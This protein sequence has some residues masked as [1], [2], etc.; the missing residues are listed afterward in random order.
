MIRV[1]LTLKLV[2]KLFID[3]LDIN[4][5]YYSAGFKNSQIEKIIDQNPHPQGP[6]VDNGCAIKKICFLK[7][8]FN[9][10]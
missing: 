8:N 1:R 6:R 7:F 5:Y 9:L 10:F 4:I 3:L 2:V